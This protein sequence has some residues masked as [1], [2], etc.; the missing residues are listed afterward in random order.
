MR[1]LLAIILSAGIILPL[2]AA[3]T[4]KIQYAAPVQLTGSGINSLSASAT[5][6][7]AMAAVDNTS[8][9]YVDDFVTVV[10][11]TSNSALGSNKVINYW[12]AGSD[13]TDP[14]DQDDTA[15]SGSAGSYTINT[16]SNLKPAAQVSAI[17]AGR[18][19]VKT[20]SVAQLF[21]GVM[22]AKFVIVE[23]NDTNQTTAASGNAIYHMGVYFTN[24]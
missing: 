21:G 23:C 16:N 20:F 6:C 1:K 12:V 24:N 15:I 17:T 11:S 22:P 9:L 8:T 14:Y 7:Y 18:Q 5:V 19:Y 2:Q 10:S 13:G 4:D 3:T